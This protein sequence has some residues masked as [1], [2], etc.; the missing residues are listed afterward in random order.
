[1]CSDA[2]MLSSGKQ[3]LTMDCMPASWRP[4]TNLQRLVQRMWR[5]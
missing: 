3:I 4:A 2:S 1:M 5:A